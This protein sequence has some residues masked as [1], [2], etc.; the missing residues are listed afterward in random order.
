MIDT[1][2][3]RVAEI[4]NYQNIIPNVNNAG[5]ATE[6]KPKSSKDDMS[7]T[8]KQLKFPKDKKVNQHSGST[9]KQFPKDKKVDKQARRSCQYFKI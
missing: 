9:R 4:A 7:P 5:V 2:Q 8:H 1:Q 3:V 6:T